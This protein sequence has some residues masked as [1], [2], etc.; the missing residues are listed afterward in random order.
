KLADKV[1]FNPKTDQSGPLSLGVASSGVGTALNGRLVVIGDSDFA[2]NA[3]VNGPGDNSDLFYN[4]IDWLA[5]QEYQISIRPKQPTDRHITMT[6]AQNAALRW[7]D[8]FFIPG[9]VII[10]G[11]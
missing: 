4:T 10:S 6:E 7:L 9:I 8:M 5:Q 2:S 1:Q 3:G 11:L